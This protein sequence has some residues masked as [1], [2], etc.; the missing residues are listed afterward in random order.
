MKPILLIICLFGLFASVACTTNPVTADTATLVPEKRII[1][2]EHLKATE[3]SGTVVIICDKGL[4]G[5][6]CTTRISANEKIIA[7]LAR[8]EKLVLHLEEGEHT[9]RAWPNGICG[10]VYAQETVSIKK[11]GTLVCRVGYKRDGNFFIA[12]DTL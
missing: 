4:M 7:D 3:E 6:G 5:A 1:S 2:T 8:G 11:T 12:P 9:L 10:G